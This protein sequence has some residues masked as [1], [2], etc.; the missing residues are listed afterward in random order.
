MILE[1]K[2]LI[3]VH[4]PKTGGTSIMKALRPYGLK[5]SGHIQLSRELSVHKIGRPKRARYTVFC[6]S[7]NPWDLVVS[8]YSYIKMEKSY[9]HSLDG[10]TNYGVHP[11]YEFV[12]DLSFKEFVYA[13]K[14]KKIKS[15]YNTLPQTYWINRKVDKVL[16][17]ENLNEDFKAL[18][19]EVGL[20]KVELPHLNK[21]THKSYKD[22]YDDELI[23]IVRKL[24]HK[25]IETFGYEF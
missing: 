21:S 23:E 2:K 18:C 6:V 7:R 3:F 24:Y 13:L 19:K 4:I 1:D 25:D 14:D 20:D 8:N 12:K 10:T 15:K 11:D 22:F 16:R 17:F 5:G 9:W